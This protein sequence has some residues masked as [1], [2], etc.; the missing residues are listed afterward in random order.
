MINVVIFFQARSV[1]FNFR[2]MSDSS[3]GEFEHHTATPNNRRGERDIFSF[4]RTPGPRIMR[5]REKVA[6]S[7]FHTT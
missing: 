2:F 5:K 4:Q 3:E 1:P 7:E 6:L